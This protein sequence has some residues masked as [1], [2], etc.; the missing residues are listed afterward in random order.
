MNKSIFFLLFATD[1][2]PLSSG[3]KYKTMDIKRLI[4]A[5]ALL[6]TLTG[7]SAKN[8][9]QIIAHRGYWDTEGAAQNSIAALTKA[10]EIQVYGSELD[11]WLSSDGVPMVNH[12]ATTP[13]HKLVLE[14]TTA[15]R[16]KQEK[17]S[18]GEHLPTLEE[19]LLKG[20]DCKYSKLIIELKA[21]SSKEREDS[22]TTKVLAMVKKLKLEKRV[23][24]I[25]FSL[26]TV[27]ELIRLNPQ[28]KVY[29]LSGNLSPKEL[30]EIGC[31]GLDYN[32]SIMK[33][34]EHWFAEAKKYG[35]KVNVWTVNKKEEMEY[36]IEKGAD[37]ITTN[38]PRLG[39]ELLNSK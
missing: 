19:Y 22:L 36:L 13:E 21:H 14:K 1:I 34:N 27:K 3:F 32:L 33:E 24:Y 2:L 25:S 8:K 10:D 20:K 16:L 35:L 15:A 5:G 6:I 37:F 38:D 7:M 23:E 11:V 29:Y 4:F 31:T 26:N 39:L 28:A 18:N 17:L 9:T 30:N 12:D